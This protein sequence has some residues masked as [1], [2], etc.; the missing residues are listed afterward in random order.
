MSTQYEYEIE[1]DGGLEY[2]VVK[3]PQG[4]RLRGMKTGDMK[5]RQDVA[6]LACKAQWT[7]L[8]PLTNGLEAYV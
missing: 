7:V 6:C 5:V 8:A 1:S 2:V 3:C 4:H